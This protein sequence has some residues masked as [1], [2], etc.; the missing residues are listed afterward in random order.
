[1]EAAQDH[2]NKEETKVVM[3]QVIEAEQGYC[4]EEE[5]GEDEN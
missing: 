2:F 4:N 3:N 5:Q 1:M